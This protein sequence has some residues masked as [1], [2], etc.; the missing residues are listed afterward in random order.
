MLGERGRE[1]YTP[2]KDPGKPE[3]HADRSKWLITRIVPFPK[4][5]IQFWTLGYSCSR[6]AEDFPAEEVDPRQ[7]NAVNTVVVR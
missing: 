3:T 7:A 2:Y 4:D 5:P 1:Y 6:I